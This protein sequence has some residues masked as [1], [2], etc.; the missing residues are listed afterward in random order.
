[1]KMV[2]ADDD[3]NPVPGS[4]FSWLDPLIIV[5]TLIEAILRS[6]ATFF[7]GMSMILMQHSNSQTERDNA[8]ELA[9]VELETIWEDEDG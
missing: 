4:P 2:W 7:R 9:A 1:M 8:L 6:F 5:S 3:G